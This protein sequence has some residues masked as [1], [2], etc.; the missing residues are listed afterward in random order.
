MSEERKRLIEQLRDTVE[1][2]SQRKTVGVMRTEHSI[3]L[4]SELILE[5]SKE[6]EEFIKAARAINNKEEWNCP[7]IAER[8]EGKLRGVEFIFQFSKDTKF[9]DIIE[10]IEARIS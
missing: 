1:F 10:E 4:P 6:T 9:K 3:F 7:V 5:Q 8:I 2:F